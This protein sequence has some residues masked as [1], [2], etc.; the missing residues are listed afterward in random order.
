M[1]IRDSFIEG[2]AVRL[3]VTR[4]TCPAIHEELRHLLQRG[5]PPLGDLDRMHLELRAQL[6]ERPLAADRLDHHPCFELR[7]VL[8][9]RRRHR[10]LL[11][12]DSVE[13]LSLLPGLKSWDHYKSGFPL[14][15][16]DL[17]HRPSG[18]A[19]LWRGA[20]AVGVCVHDLQRA[21]LVREGKPTPARL[22]RAVAAD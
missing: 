13:N 10:P 7:T 21:P 9:S 18:W 11:V 5:L 3:T 20:G 14:V 12:N 19:Q 2:V 15:V 16:A 4:F 8:F 6:A 17:G 1:C 22:C